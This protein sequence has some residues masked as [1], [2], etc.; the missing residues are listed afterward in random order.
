MGGVYGGVGQPSDREIVYTLIGRYSD[1]RFIVKLPDDMEFKVAAPLM[2]AGISIYGGIR[3]ANIP[4]GGS[5]GI[6]GIGGLGHI[7]IQIAKCMVGFHELL[8]FILGRRPMLNENIGLHCR[9]SRRQTAST[10]SC[11]FI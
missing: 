2:C 9:R 10:G 6:I 11:G 8:K 7:G 4:E 5:I 3:R 1:A